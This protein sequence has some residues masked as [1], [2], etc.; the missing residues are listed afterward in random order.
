M[1]N[2]N[3]F[4]DVFLSL[5]YNNCCCW[6]S[7]SSLTHFGLMLKV[8]LWEALVRPP[9]KPEEKVQVNK[10]FIHIHWHKCIKHGRSTELTLIDPPAHVRITYISFGCLHDF[11]VQTT[12]RNWTRNTVF[13]GTAC[14]TKW[15][16]CVTFSV[17]SFNISDIISDSE[18][19]L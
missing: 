10:F 6:Q 13:S 17:S 19:T 5:Q 11:N 4:N 1:L 16:S 18:C 2:L 14:V 9:S 3:L 7:V 12:D 8:L 15:S